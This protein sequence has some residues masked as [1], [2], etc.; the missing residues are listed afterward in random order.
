M[1]RNPR[2]KNSGKFMKLSDF[3]AFAK[4]KTISGVTIKINVSILK[5]YHCFTF[6]IIRE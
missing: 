4:E 6:Q 2:F 3:L 5:L 1:V